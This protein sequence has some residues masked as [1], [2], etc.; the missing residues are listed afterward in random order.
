MDSSKDL[1]FPPPGEAPLHRNAPLAPTQELAYRKKCIDLRKRLAEIEANN[2]ATRRRILQENEHVQ[3][4]R[5]LRAIL[6]NQLKEIMST[7]AKHLSDEQLERVRAMAAGMN[8]SVAEQLGP[9][10][11]QDLQPNSLADGEGLLDDSSEETVEDEPEPAERPERRRRVNNTYRETIMNTDP[12]TDSISSVYQQSSLPNLAPANSSYSPAPPPIDP[13][14]M[15]SSFR[16]S[17][18]TPQAV[19][20]PGAQPQLAPEPRYG[21]SSPI[22]MNQH[23]GMPYHGS[24]QPRPPSLSSNTVDSNGVGR[25]PTVATRPERPETPYNQ[26]TA[27]MRPQLEADNYPQDQIAARIKAEWE[28]LSAENRK[29]WDDRYEDQMREYQA[30][31]DAFKRASRREASS[32]GFSAIN[33]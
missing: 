13:A 25:A 30:A 31:M 15:T 9:A 2:D 8:T 32:G 14:A 21:Q 27:H 19:G 33:S 26:F 7:P 29:L 23:L 12:P 1:A 6:L 4:M 17:S 20:T 28:N 10:V 24:T 5:L 11:S 3:K 18:A 22:A 16:I